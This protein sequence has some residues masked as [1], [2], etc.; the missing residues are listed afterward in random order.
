M[1]KSAKFGLKMGTILEKSTDLDG[2]LTN[3][4]GDLPTKPSI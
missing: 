4:I 1:Y 2:L 3:F